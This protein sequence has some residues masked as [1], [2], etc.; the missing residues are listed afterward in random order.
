LGWL[1]EFVVKENPHLAQLFSQM[2]R[3]EEL[4]TGLRNVY[5]YIRQY[6]GSDKLLLIEDE[7]L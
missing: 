1:T 3:S 4:G 5:R 7:P 2:G 6:S